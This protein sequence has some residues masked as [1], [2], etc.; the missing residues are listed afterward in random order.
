MK[1]SRNN[2]VLLEFN[3]EYQDFHY[4]Q[5]IDGIPEREVDTN[6]YKKLLFFK[7]IE[8]ANFFC[9]FLV[10]QFGLLDQDPKKLKIKDALHTLNN[11]TRFIGAYNDLHKKIQ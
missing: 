1:N 5:F 6:G 3:E 4:N 2:Y 7:D 10:I 8:E 11:L 9:D